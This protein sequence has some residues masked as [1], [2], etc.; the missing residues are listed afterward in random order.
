MFVFVLPT[1]TKVRLYYVFNLS[2]FKQINQETGIPVGTQ[3]GAYLTTAE[4]LAGGRVP[5]HH[6]REAALN[7]PLRLPHHAREQRLAGGDVVDET[8]HAPRRPHADSNTH[9][10]VSDG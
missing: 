10:S 5:L 3:L 7:D 4:L 1:F 6:L 2:A 8:H 9:A